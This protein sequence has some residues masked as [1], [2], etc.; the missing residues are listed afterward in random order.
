M[1]CRSKLRHSIGKNYA[2]RSRSRYLTCCRH[3]VRGSA[4]FCQVRCLFIAAAIVVCPLA[5]RASC[6][7]AAPPAYED[8][9]Y[10]KVSQYALVGQQHPWY[11]YEAAYYIAGHHANVSLNAHRAV[12]II[13]SFVSTKPLDSFKNVVQA[14]ERDRSFAMRLRPAASLYLDGPEDSV[15]VSRCGVTTTLSSVTSSQELN[16]DDAQGKAF[17]ALLSDL[18]ETIFR[19][20]WETP[21]RQP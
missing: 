6:D 5:A 17:F 18:R 21:P 7:T 9:T 3:A 4:R 19:Q 20:K 15:T 1:K 16:L 10:I 12:G 8:I 11:T 13:G 2:G 14:L